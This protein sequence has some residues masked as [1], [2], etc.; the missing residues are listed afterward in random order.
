MATQRRDFLK[1]TGF[2]A[3]TPWLGAGLAACGGG[4][5]DADML[6]TEAQL[7]LDAT[8]AVAAIRDGRMTAEAYVSTLIAR[9]KALSDLNALIVL[10]EAGALTAARAVDAARTAGT[11][12]GPLAGLPIVVKDNINTKGLPTTG[13]TA[14]LRN[15]QP[16]AN[17]P[18]LQKLIDA[19]AIVLGKSNLHE[20]AFG[21]TSTNLTSFA[22]AVKNP[23][24]KT[25]IP[26]GSSGGTAAAIAARIVPAGLGT[27]TGGSTRVPAALC[28]IA[29]LRPSV[30]NGGAQRRYTNTNAVVPISHTRDTVGPMARS[31]AD[32]ALLDSVV[33]GRAIASAIGLRGLRIGTP[34]SFW[35]GLEGA[36]ATVM[37]AARNKLAAAGV[38]FVDVDTTGLA[39]LNSLVSF[40][41]A[42]HEPIADIPAYLAATGVSGI[43]VADI[44]AQVASPDVKGAFGA[45]LA[46]AFG[47][48]YPD[49]INV[50]RPKMQALYASYFADNALDAMMFPTTIL[51]AAPIDAVNGS[52]TVSID[53]GPPA[54]TFG[55]FIRN[56]DP[57]SNA[58]IPGLSIPA[59]LTTSGLP[60]GLEID[61][62]LGSDDRLIGIGLSIETALGAVP[63]PAL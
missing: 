47:A 25:R 20:L 46:D 40:Q 50:Q 44:A 27:D 9:A 53:G 6:N 3:T 26:G 28:G 33:T 56:T 37:T 30:G 55:T 23:Y 45:I 22:G 60:V 12:L 57:G 51:A 18:T 59:G 14:A 35:A 5:D 63:A 15:V 2:L 4:N 29:G 16:A 17:A 24:D 48:A 32:I 39:A 43:T 61:G 58:G 10:D 13:G 31:V 8:Q 41:I 52:S 19:G 1:H 38:V 36:V 54:D 11:A 21:I 49:A 34:A 62:P 7:K 42:L